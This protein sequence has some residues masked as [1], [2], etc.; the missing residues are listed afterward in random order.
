[1]MLNSKSRFVIAKDNILNC[2]SR[3]IL[4]IP[5]VLN[6]YLAVLALADILSHFLHGKLGS[7]PSRGETKEEEQGYQRYY[8]VIKHGY[9]QEV[10]VYTRLNQLCL[11]KALSCK[12]Y[13]HFGWD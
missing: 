9:Q 6:F 4:L 3:Y 1:M 5:F 2:F 11:F 13:T 7:M 10:H 12:Q 8:L